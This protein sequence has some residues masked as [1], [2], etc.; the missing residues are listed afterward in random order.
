MEDLQVPV[1]LLNS[2]AK[3]FAV[4]ISILINSQCHGEIPENIDIRAAK[5]GPTSARSAD[6]ASCCHLEA[7]S[8]ALPRNQQ[9]CCASLVRSDHPERATWSDKGR[10][11][12]EFHCRAIP[13]PSQFFGP[14]YHLR[15]R[16]CS[17]AAARNRPFR[18][19]RL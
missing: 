2:G 17:G 12:I 11:Q 8:G 13:S 6:M 19:A 18:F 16:P 15:A 7:E 10:F 4:Y 3:I 14:S 9:R 5:I 1:K